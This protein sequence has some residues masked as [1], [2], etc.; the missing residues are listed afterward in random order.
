MY[1]CYVVKMSEKWIG[2]EFSNLDNTCDLTRGTA[3]PVTPS[4]AFFI[5]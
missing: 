4:A 2:I 1:F 5:A 3:A